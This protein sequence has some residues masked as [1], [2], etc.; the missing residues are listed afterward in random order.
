MDEFRGGFEVHSAGRNHG[1]LRQWGFEGLD[2]FWSADGPARENLYEVAAGSPGSDHFG[3][4]ERSRHHEL[5]KTPGLRDRVW[6]EARTYDELRSCVNAML[7]GFGIEHS[8][9]TD[10]D[11]CS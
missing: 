11:V 2:V 9:S 8:S 5:A 7:S 10:N 4:G 6:I 3:W 1:D